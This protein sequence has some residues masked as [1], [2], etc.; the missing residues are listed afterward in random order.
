MNY[1]QE[2]DILRKL[3]SVEDCCRQ[4]DINKDTYKIDK[5]MK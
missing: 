3:I 4:F 1:S 2:S 5:G